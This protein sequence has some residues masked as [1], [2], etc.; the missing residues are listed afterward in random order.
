MG[1]S[2]RSVEPTLKGNGKGGALRA[3]ECGLPRC[4]PRTAQAI[5]ALAARSIP[6]G[7]GARRGGHGTSAGTRVGGGGGI[8]LDRQK[9]AAA[10]SALGELLFLA[11]LLTDLELP[12]DVADDKNYC[13]TCTACLDACP[14]AAFPSP[15]VLDAR[16]CISYL[17]IE[18]R[19]AIEPEPQSQLAGWVFGC[20][21]CQQVCPWNR[22][23]PPGSEPEFT[24]AMTWF[25]SIFWLCSI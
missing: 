18:H 13:G 25:S 2:T 23:V 22:R 24:P 9:H 1:D 7:G 11:A 10:Q 4:D 5:A 12:A 19:E 16:R 20:D 8:G 6:G 14:T 17:T 15:F 21:V 3:G